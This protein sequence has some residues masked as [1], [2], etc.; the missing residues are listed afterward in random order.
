MSDER[1]TLLVAADWLEEQGQ[2]EFAE[3]VREAAQLLADA[4]WDRDPL[5]IGPHNGHLI[6]STWSVHKAQNLTAQDTVRIQ[7][8]LE[9]KFWLF[10]A[11]QT[12]ALRDY[13]ICVD[14]IRR[15]RRRRTTQHGI[16][17]LVMRG[18][19]YTRKE[20]E[21][22]QLYEPY[23]DYATYDPENPPSS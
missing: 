23:L 18:C 22:P 1:D 16:D 21:R 19:L 11:K 5:P 3:A 2:N 4:L 20:N 9:R 10:V 12:Y 8:E 17:D 15:F 6:E 13:S 14:E 7:E